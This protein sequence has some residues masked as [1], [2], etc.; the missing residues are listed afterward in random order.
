MNRTLRSIPRLGIA[1][2]SVAA[3]SLVLAACSSESTPAAVASSAPAEASAVASAAPSAAAEV[4]PLA[5]KT[6]AYIQAG[7][8]EYYALSAKGAEQAAAALGGTAKV[9]NSA[10]DP[11]KELA[12][13]NDAIAQGV[14]GIVL[15]PLSDASAKAELK[16]ANDAG[17]PMTVLYGYSDAVASMGAGFVQIDFYNYAKALGEAFIKD[18]PS[19]PVAIISG[20]LGR[21]EV[22]A[23]REGFIAGFGDESRIVEEVAGDYSR[24]KALNAAQDIITKHP[25]L[26]GLVVGNEDMAVGAYAGLGDKASQ[27]K[28]ATQNGSPEGN[29]YLEEGKF[30][31]TVGGSPSQESA[32]A[33]NLL[34]QAIAGT[35]VS[36]KLCLTPWAVNTT[37]LIQSVD[38]IPTPEIITGALQVPAPCSAN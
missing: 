8:I 6:I 24:Q 16:L 14:D 22:T 19:G 36:S 31:V 35:P 9:F 17:I 29:K 21:S 25:D 37:S 15:F 10:F 13:V 1:A 7:D 4:M 11:Q 28:I 26:A 33:V 3:L 5:G 12:N 32:L 18:V 23:F 34:A 2:A 27:V 30:A 38:W 20:Q